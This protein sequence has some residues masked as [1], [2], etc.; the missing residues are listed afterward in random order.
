MK[1]ALLEAAVL[2]AA[3]ALEE[4][5]VLLKRA[6]AWVMRPRLMPTRRSP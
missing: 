2:E 6:T 3:A 5:A 1:Q 4:A